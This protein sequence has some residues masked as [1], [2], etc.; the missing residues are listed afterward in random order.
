[1]TEICDCT[2]WQLLAQERK[3]VL[4]WAAGVLMVYW[5]E[6]V[7][8]SENCEA[9]EQA[10]ANGEKQLESK[11]PKFEVGVPEVVHTKPEFRARFLRNPTRHSQAM[12]AL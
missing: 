12:S 9:C 6:R 10:G 2:F 5:K 4:M 3:G 11:R 1:M 8:T 7:V